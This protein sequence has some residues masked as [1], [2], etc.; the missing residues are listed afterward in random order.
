MV[1]EDNEN[2][3]ALMQD[4]VARCGVTDPIYF[5]RDAEGVIDYLSGKNVYADRNRHPL[6]N[7]LLIDLNLPHAS[8][9]ELLKWFTENPKHRLPTLVLTSSADEK[10]IA[11]AYDL[12]ASTYFLKPK[13]HSQLCALMKIIYD[14]W[15]VARMP[16]RKWRGF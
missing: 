15:S 3:I 7:L 11:K 14:Y 2:D 12:S 1:L 5:V 10:E 9:L 16:D 8:G 4:A 13:S 6:P